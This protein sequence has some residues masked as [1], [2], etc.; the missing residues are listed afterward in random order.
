[1]EIKKGKIKF[2]GGRLEK[3]ETDGGMKEEDEKIHMKKKKI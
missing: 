2:F 1:M 3:R